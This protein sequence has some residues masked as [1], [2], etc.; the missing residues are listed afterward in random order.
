MKK[1]LL[2]KIDLEIISILQENAAITNKELAKKI[3][4]SEPPTLIR[5][6]NLVEN[7]IIE[8]YS[9]IINEDFLGI[10]LKVKFE[11]KIKEKHV[12]FL[13]D[14]LKNSIHTAFL[15]VSKP[16][17]ITNMVNL[18]SIAIFIKEQEIA[19]YKELFKKNTHII[20]F[21]IYPIYKIIKPWTITLKQSWV[22]EINKSKKIN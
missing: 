17:E 10:N 13:A 11:S 3:G 2:D 20:D 1:K 9:A 12:Q 16:E 18:T 19:D 22:D 21:K 6:R 7:N 5:V 14:T 8:K 15:S 4:L